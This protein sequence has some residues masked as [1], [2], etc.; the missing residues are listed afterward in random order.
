MKVRR[1]Q[2]IIPR[3]SRSTV[4]GALLAVGMLVGSSHRGNG[5]DVRG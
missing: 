2:S 3:V 5:L 4:A 1:P